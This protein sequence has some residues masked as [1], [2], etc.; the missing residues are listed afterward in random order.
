MKRIS[1]RLE[2][3]QEYQDLLRQQEETSPEALQA[4][5]PSPDARQMVV[6][7]QGVYEP[8][9]PIRFYSGA[10]GDPALLNQPMLRGMEAARRGLG[11]GVDLA[12]Q[13]FLEPAVDLSAPMQASMQS[14]G[15]RSQMPDVAPDVM[16]SMSPGQQASYQFMQAMNDPAQVVPTAV[17]MMEPTPFEVAMAGTGVGIPVAGMSKLFRSGANLLSGAKRFGTVMNVVKEAN[18]A[19]ATRMRNLLMGDKKLQEAVSYLSPDEILK[20]ASTGDANARRNLDTMREFLEFAPESKILRAAAK[21]GRS[22]QGWYENSRNTIEHVFGDDAGLFAGILAATS[23]QTSVESNMQNA[24]AFYNNWV[25]AGRPTSEA[26]VNQLLAQSVQGSKGD[27][28]VLNAWRN[29]VIEVVKGGQTISGPKVDSF[30]TNLRSRPRTMAYSEVPPDEAVTLDAWM[31]ALF[32][33]SKDTFSGAGTNLAK[34]DPGLSPSYLAGTALTRKTARE[35]GISA[36]EVQETTWSFAKALYEKAQNLGM[37][38]ED[39]LKKNLL[40]DAEIAGTVDFAL[41]M[42]Q[43]QYAGLLKDV[44]TVTARLSTMPKGRKPTLS[45]LDPSEQKYAAQAANVLGRV[46][47]DR[48]AATAM[49]A[50]RPLENAAVTQATME[51]TPSTR[52]PFTLSE[53]QATRVMAASKD[54]AGRNL[55]QEGLTGR[56]IPVQSGIGDYMGVNNPVMSAGT[57]ATT[58]GDRLIP[59][60]ALNLDLSNILSGTAYAQESMGATALRFGGSG[61]K[62][63]MRFTTEKQLTPQMIQSIKKSL[64]SDNWIVNT[65]K[66]GADIV[67]V[68][69]DPMDLTPEMQ[70]QMT[71]AVRAASG[72]KIQSKAG[73][74]LASRTPSVAFPGASV[75]YVEMPISNPATRAQTQLLAQA[76]TNASR[77]QVRR[78][79]SPQ[80]KRWARNTLDAYQKVEGY[81]P[82]LQNYLRLIAEGG[83][84]RLM[85][86]MKDP[87]MALPALAAVGMTPSLL[88]SWLGAEE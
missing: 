54:L 52:A 26:R 12:S 35:L 16:A 79:D 58:R 43:P 82:E 84:S 85:D 20:L 75:G 15:V 23:P 71:Q 72:M 69:S 7:P 22:K 41:L 6:N 9:E 62:D 45:A 31:A 24:L 40:S 76:L 50:G 4:L 39:V 1:F 67:W 42:Q 3:T 55:V 88:E 21:V 18:P 83:V 10:V 59:R 66:D 74:N 77:D 73:T 86:A 53:N 11:A 32:G 47:Q 81:P 38:P 87:N 19:A 49:R 34:A 63:A 37:T 28:S 44:P 65:R 8:L 27:Q 33:M 5:L 25:K 57:V 64:G 51:V 30:W 60:E 46:L 2:D 48:Q 13:V 56:A 14:R 68:G 78:L 36:A 29:N 80:V 61:P 17:E 70:Q